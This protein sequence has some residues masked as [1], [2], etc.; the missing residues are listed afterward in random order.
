MP[1]VR[2]GWL[3][4][5]PIPNHLKYS[6]LG[7]EKPIPILL[8]LEREGRKLNDWTL[9]GMINRVF[10]RAL[11]FLRCEMSKL[12][13]QFWRSWSKLHLLFRFQRIKILNKVK[14]TWGG[15][16]EGVEKIWWE[17]T[18]L[19][20]EACLR[21]SEMGEDTPNKVPEGSVEAI[22]DLILSSW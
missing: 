14:W 3:L 19:G 16:V 11:F 20:I 21:I 18:N 13:C 17:A 9:E 10:C 5:A 2:T 1:V 22:F 12:V 4:K 8:V 7:L 15:V 6:L